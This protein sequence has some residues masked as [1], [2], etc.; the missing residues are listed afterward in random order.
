M[1]LKVKI[2]RIEKRT[3]LK[4]DVAV[5]G[6]EEAEGRDAL[7]AQRRLDLSVRQEPWHI[8]NQHTLLGKTQYYNSWRKWQYHIVL[9]YQTK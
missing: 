8:P 7:S 4:D 3:Y 5:P 9:C 2:Q 1:K 6:A